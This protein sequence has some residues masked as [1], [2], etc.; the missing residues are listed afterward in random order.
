[1][2]ENGTCQH[3]ASD[4]NEL[5]SVLQRDRHAS[6]EAEDYKIELK[7][8]HEVFTLLRKGEKLLCARA[9][10][11]GWMNRAYEANI[12]LQSTGVEDL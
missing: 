3:A 7:N 5:R 8:G 1:M 6:Q 12:E 2:D 9:M 11:N 4:L 10:Y